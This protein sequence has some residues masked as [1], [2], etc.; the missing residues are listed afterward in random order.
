MLQQWDVQLHLDGGVS[1]LDEAEEAAQ[2]DNATDALKWLMVGTHRIRMALKELQQ[3]DPRIEQYSARVAIA[4]SQAEQLKAA[5]VE[6]QRQKP[7]EQLLGGSRWL[8]E[9]FVFET[10]GNFKTAIKWYSAGAYRIRLALKEL[11]QK[12][13]T[14]I[15]E[16]Y[17]VLVAIANSRAEQL[18]A[19][20]VQL[21]RQQPEEQLL[22]GS[23]MLDDARVSENTGN[24]THTFK[25]YKVGAYR[26][27]L[28]LKELQN[29]DPRI[30]QY[31]THVDIVNSPAEQLKAVCISLRVSVPCLL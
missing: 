22:G 5:G 21:Q 7:E 17:I 8:D 10:N 26:V 11:Q 25:L 20:G 3:G 18:K 24:F 12:R 30:E 15:I 19:A 16:Q 23:R 2:S 14:S 9:A 1:M 27:R 13:D 31:S 28:A 29:G 4:N 6:V